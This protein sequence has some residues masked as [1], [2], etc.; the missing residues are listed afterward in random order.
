MIEGGRTIISDQ[1]SICSLLITDHYN[2]NFEL[3]EDQQ[4]IL[5]AVKE[6][7]EEELAP[8]ADEIDRK[9]EFPWEN[10]KLMADYNLS[11]I[12]IPEE[13]GGLGADFVTWALVGEELAKACSTTGSIYGANILC[14]YPIY[15]FGTEEQKRKYLVPL[16]KGETI[17]A[18]GLTEPNAGSDA[19]GGLMTAVKDGD[20][21]ILNGT[22][23][24]IS[25]GGMAQTYVVTTKTQLHR[26]ARGMSAFIVEKGTPGFSFGKQE[27]KMCFHAQA[28]CELIFQDCRIPA[29]NLL[30]QENRGFRVA[31][32]TLDVGRIGMAVGAIGLAKAAMEKAVK[33][34]KERIQFGQRISTFQAIQHKLA[35]MATEIE[36]A[37]LLMFK[38]A[39]LR[40]QNKP[41]GDIA[42][43]AKLYSSEMCARVTSQAVQ[44]HGGYGLIREYT[45]ER[46]MRESKLFEIVEGT[47]EIQRNVIALHVLK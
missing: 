25:N 26:G 27:E 20:E 30:G 36:A 6:I 9:G 14:I 41:F 31:M 2:M 15:M 11:G 46:Y 4:I 24:F 28:N 12:P 7:C 32:E 37:E 34:S 44:I 1:H 18:F 16:A 5:D 10:V 33:Y 21:Y 35:N 47:S 43:M 39:W 45:V 40:D 8:K 42:A 3:T 17:G 23:I 38:A 29:E 22:K 13:Y 19:A